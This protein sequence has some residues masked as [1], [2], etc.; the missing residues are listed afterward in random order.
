MRTALKIL[1]VLMTLMTVWASCQF[2]IVNALISFF[3]I[4]LL[5]AGYIFS[6]I[7]DSENEDI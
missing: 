7:I 4:P 3:S 5:I 6:T 1:L 2:D